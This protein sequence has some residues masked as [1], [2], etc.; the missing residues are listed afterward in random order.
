MDGIIKQ[1]YKASIQVIKGHTINLKWCYVLVFKPNKE[2]LRTELECMILKDEQKTL[3]ATKP[4]EVII[5]SEMLSDDS[6][7]INIGDTFIIKED[8]SENVGK[9]IILEILEKK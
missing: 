4:T 8:Y 6:G 9:G 7:N 5:T 3:S 1:V 2:G